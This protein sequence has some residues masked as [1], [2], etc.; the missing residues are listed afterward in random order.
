MRPFFYCL[1]LFF[2]L[3]SLLMPSL[4]MAGEYSNRED[5][6]AF[7]DKMVQDHQ[8]DKTELTTWLDSAEKKQAI[9]DAIARPA[10]K[11]KTWKDYRAIFLTE[12][13]IN[14]G[15]QFWQENAK[16]L[17]AV[18]DRYGVPP[19][20]II[21]ILG[22]ETRYGRTTGN[23]RVIDAL[24][25]LG[26]DYPPRAKFFVGQLEH[27]FLLA[28]EQHHD[29]LDLKGSYAGAMGYGQFIPSSYRHYA[30]D[31]NGDQFAD[32]WNSPDDAIASVGNYFK[33]NGWKPNQPIVMRCRIRDDY[34]AAALEL[35]LKP[36]LRRKE[37]ET[38]GFLPIG[39]S[40]AN[41]LFAVYKL[42]GEYGSEFWAGAKNF[43][44]ITRYNQSNMYAL[45][46]YQLSQAIKE[47]HQNQQ[48]PILNWGD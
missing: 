1:S 26:F 16:T 25:T 42:E 28:R 29:P 21:A 14:M 13:R 4:S 36:T 33:E 18:E 24:A 41:E 39:D 11:E 43:Y 15:V 30:V 37:I 27:F 35:G 47:R 46:A 38:R 22:V 6:T 19:E 23:Y 20:M 44:V 17:A 40:S 45:A 3:P 48:S 31:F 10:E 8:F 5:V 2:I 12:E 7:I 34:D 9:L 32:I